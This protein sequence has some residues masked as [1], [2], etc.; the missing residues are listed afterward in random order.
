[1]QIHLDG[2]KDLFSIHK[3]CVKSSS[4]SPEFLGK[5]AQIG[6]DENC[7]DK[8]SHLFKIAKI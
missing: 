3:I 1:M 6:K 5:E 2:P 4:R 8:A 7:V